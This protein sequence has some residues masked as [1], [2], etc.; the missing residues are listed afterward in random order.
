MA[1]LFQYL[2]SP[3]TR[4]R[5]RNLFTRP[6]IYGILVNGVALSVYYFSS[7]SLGPYVFLVGLIG[8]FV[9][10]VLSERDREVIAAPTAGV[11]G[12]I[13]FFLVYLAYGAS[14]AS[15]YEYVTATWVFGGFVA[16]TVAWSFLLLGGFFLFG[17]VLGWLVWYAKGY[18]K[19]RQRS[20]SSGQ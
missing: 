19:R 7:M 16:M 15:A 2:R 5:L 11:F 17:I 20:L 1:G 10:A 8:P 18:W 9:T 12:T 14:V 3:R 6:V 4:L 13:L